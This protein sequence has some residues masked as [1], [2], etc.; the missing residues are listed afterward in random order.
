MP[1]RDR[2]GPAG[3]G[4]M[5]GRGTGRCGLSGYYS[6]GLGQ[7]LQQASPFNV[8]TNVTSTRTS[9]ATTG[10]GTL[11][12]EAALRHARAVVAQR[13]GA[14]SA[15]AA[16]PI[17]FSLA[18]RRDPATQHKTLQMSAAQAAATGRPSVGSQVA[19]GGG[20]GAPPPGGTA[21]QFAA[22]CKNVGG[23]VIGPLQCQL[24]DGAIM[25][26]DA[27]GQGVCVN[28]VGQCAGA[29]VAGAGKGALA[30]GAA[31]LAALMLLR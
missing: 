11:L 23:S 10:G 20:G 1:G 3:Y 21:E 9:G 27:Q 5:T 12:D 28:A 13:A 14:T 24:A 19:A 22:A 25:T 2:T 8:P 17:S 15:A 26:V 18:L 31:A 29:A 7:V 6:Y 16:L 4:P 30:I